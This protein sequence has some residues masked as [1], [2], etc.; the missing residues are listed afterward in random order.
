MVTGTSVVAAA[1]AQIF[2]GTAAETITAGQIVYQ[3][4]TTTPA[5]QLRRALSTTI[6]QAAA[7]GVAL[8]GA[9]VSQPVQYIQSG[10]LNP[11]ATAV[12]GE[13]YCVSANAGGIAPVADQTAGKYTTHLGIATTASNISILIRASGVAHA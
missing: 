1:G 9:S 5:N 8:N 12:V 7:V 13:T 6:A 11:G 2:S 4:S 10:G 3:D